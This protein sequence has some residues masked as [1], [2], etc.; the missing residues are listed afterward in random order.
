M[1]LAQVC[2]EVRADDDGKRD[3][4]LERDELMLR[5]G[6]LTFPHA[7][8]HGYAEGLTPTSWATTQ[9]CQRLNIPASYF[10]R[11][12]PELQDEQ[13]NYWI[14]HV[15]QNGHTH[16]PKAERWLLRTKDDGLRGVLTERYAC[17]DNRDVLETLR[18]LIEPH[19]QVGWFALTDE[20]FHLRLLDP[21]LAR[22]VLPHDRLVA[23]VHLANSEVGKRAVTV[24]AMVYRLVCSNGL[25]RLVRGSS[26]MHQ[27][28]VSW[29]KPRFEVALRQ[30]VHEALVH[31]VGFIERMSWATTMGVPDMDT[32]LDQL[33]QRWGLSQTTTA[34]VR[35]SLLD[36]PA[37]QQDTLYG[38]ANAVTHAAQALPAD[39]RYTLETLAGDLVEKGLPGLTSVTGNDARQE[40][41]PL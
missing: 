19:Y 26:L 10:K 31:G 21:K 14:D 33:G 9:V 16:A 29:S 20:S 39:D 37:G 6:R 41:L 34:N 35:Q 8:E 24:D 17:L 1:D 15:G 18:P 36:M 3:L 28:H 4:L 32:A 23:G 13:F 11:C 38:L 25:V 12:P 22:E 5:H 7:A 27:R 2:D 40:A 30:A